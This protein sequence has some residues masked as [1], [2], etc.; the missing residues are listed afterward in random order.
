MPIAEFQKLIRKRQDWVKSSNENN[1]NFD[2]ILTGLYNDPSHFVYEI[3]QNAEDAG[4][5]EVTFE[6]HED[7]L[8]IYHD[9]ED[10][11]FE[12]VE[13]V[14]GIGSSKKKDDINAIGKFGVGFKSVFA[15]TQTPIIRSGEYHFKIDDFVVPAHLNKEQ[16]NATKIVLPFEHK[17]RSRED[18]F[19]LV[20][21]KIEDIGLKSLLFLRNIEEVKWKSPHNRGHYLKS[22]KAIDNLSNTRRVTI[23]SQAIDGEYI[24]IERPF[25]IEI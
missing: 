21:D 1:F 16:I 23:V 18:I 13:G 24:V 20:N 19:K 2:G 11:D 4:A 6:L 15:I 9:G 3:L 22:A 7:R 8:E 14:T 17:I 5:T 25:E 10:F 12:D